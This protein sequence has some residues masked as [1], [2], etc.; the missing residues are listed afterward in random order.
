MTPQDSAAVPERQTP[1][2]SIVI[3]SFNR[4]AQL[5]D[6]LAALGTGFQIIVVDNGTGESLEQ[7]AAEFPAVRLSRLPKNFGLTKALNIGL[8]S[9]EGEY[10]LCLHDD[11][12]ITA[13]AVLRLADVLE[14]RPDVGA[15]CPL[16]T[17]LAGK[18]IPQVRPLPTPGNPDPALRLP[19]EGEE[20]AVECIT[21]AALLF[22]SFFLRALRQVDERYGNYG[23]AIELSAQ[24]RKAARKVIVLHSVTAIHEISPSPMRQS[25]LAGDRAAGTAVFLAKH[26]GLV[27]GLVY[28]MKTAVTALFTFRFSVATGC[29]SGQKIDGTA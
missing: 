18:P 27:S 6:N 8:R 23:S 9:A 28:R 15:V 10:I 16:L 3:V 12:K 29:L 19:P 13:D 17:D 14:A 2:I 4:L 1:R 25:A 26:H 20:T 11:V 21:G 24:M 5:R 22:R 7:L